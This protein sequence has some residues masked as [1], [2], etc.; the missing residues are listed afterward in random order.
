MSFVVKEV[1]ANLINYYLSNAFVI[2]NYS[3]YFIVLSFAFSIPSTITLGCTDNAMLCSACLS[4]YP[5]N[6]TIE[7]VP[8]P[9]ISSWAVAALA[10]IM[11]VGWWIC[12][13]WSNTFPSF[14]S[15]TCP[16]PPT[17]ILSVPFGPRLVFKISC[18][19]LDAFIEIPNAY[20]F[21]TISAFGFKY[22]RELIKIIN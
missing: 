18:K 13:Y 15:L 7:V 11:A 4:N 3:R 16:A 22:W 8:S 6:K 9:T 14:V 10:I 1:L 20:T 19:L 5:I 17:S 21:L 2:L 12:I